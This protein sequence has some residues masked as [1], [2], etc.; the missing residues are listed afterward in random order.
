[1]VRYQSALRLTTCASTTGALGQPTLRQLPPQ[2]TCDAR[3]SSMRLMCALMDTT[4]SCTGTS[5][6]TAWSA[7]ESGQRKSV[8][9]AVHCRQPYALDRKAVSSLRA[10]PLLEE[11]VPELIV[12]APRAL[13]AGLHCDRM[14]DAVP[15][16]R[17]RKVDGTLNEFRLFDN[18]CAHRVPPSKTCPT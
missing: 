4:K 11:F 15:L 18:H 7:A 9:P 14:L 12:D 1:M 5:T 16:G 10:Q 6:E 17:V 13:L 8:G 2:R 3:K